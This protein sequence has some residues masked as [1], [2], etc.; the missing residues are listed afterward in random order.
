MSLDTRI[1]DQEKDASVGAGNVATVTNNSLNVNIK[2]ITEG[3]SVEEGNDFFLDIARNKFSTLG[4][5]FEFGRNKASSTAE[6]VIWD[7]GGNYIFLESADTLDIVSDSVNDTLAGTGART[8]IIFGLDD[9]FLDI[10]ETITLNGT[11]PVTTVNSFLR[12]FRALVVTDGNESAV[13]GSN[14]GIISMSTTT[15]A[16]LQARIL[17]NNG[18]TLM[19]IYTVSAGKTAYITGISLNVGQGKQCLFRAKF[20]NCTIDDC[21]FSVKYAIDVF[22]NT[23]F[24]ELKVP[25]KVPEKTDIIFTS[26]TSGAPDVTTTASFGVI[27][28]DN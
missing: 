1:T 7:G 11:T 25:L 2:E 17:P 24:G 21:S 28:E 14:D 8:L 22:E 3:V 26:E 27:L 15:G 20:R 6:E 4:S 10:N 9:N 23:F 16:T 12:T 13:L 18:Q 5:N 19:A